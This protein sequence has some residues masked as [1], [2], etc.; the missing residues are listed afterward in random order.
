LYKYF[1][2]HSGLSEEKK[3]KNVKEIIKLRIF[4]TITPISVSERHNR[5]THRSISFLFKAVCMTL[6]WTR[7]SEE[8]RTLLGMWG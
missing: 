7:V 2:S 3:K 5:Y 6:S 4:V 1:F 8:R